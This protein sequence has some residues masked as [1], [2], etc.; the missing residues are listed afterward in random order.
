[1]KNSIRKIIITK[2]LILTNLRDLG[3]ESGDILFITADLM[4]VGLALKNK[5]ALENMWVEILKEAVGENGSVIL[6]SYT[7]TF[8][9]FMK[10]DDIIFHR[11]CKSTS[12][13]LSNILVRDRNCIRSSHPTNSYVGFGV[14]ASEILKK[15]NENG[16]SYDPIGEII[17]AGGKNL[18]LGALD[19]KN[20]PMAM[21]YAQQVLGDTKKHPFL[22]LTQTYY[23][24]CYGERKIYTKW[25]AGGCSSGGQN[26]IGQLIV[27]NAAT[28]GFVGRSY[29]MLIDGNKSYEI[30]YNALKKTPSIIKCNNNLCITCYGK[31]NKAPISSLRIYFHYINKIIT[32]I[33]VRAK[34]L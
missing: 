25:D 10:I 4:K 20:A 34:K 29:S 13:S 27:K 15:H 3:V 24:D 2:E 23:F 5:Q 32:K 17:N 21:H 9:R 28:I 30:I 1:M 19:D 22:G 6:A 11:Y 7:P 26:L 8:Y 16:L 31:W 33:R 18:I 12:G 14:A